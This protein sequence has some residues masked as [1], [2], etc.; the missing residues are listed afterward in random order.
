[1]NTLVLLRIIGQNSFTIS[2]TVY[3]L[4][5]LKNVRDVI[6]R[7]MGVDVRMK[8]ANVIRNVSGVWN[9]YFVQV[10]EYKWGE[11]L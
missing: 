1:M 2:S 11:I 3:S 9:V 10:R 6:E 5:M 8:R 4:R 7:R